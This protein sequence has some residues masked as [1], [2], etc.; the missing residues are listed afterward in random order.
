M[1]QRGSWVIAR[2]LRVELLL[3][4][5]RDKRIIAEVTSKEVV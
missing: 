4:R 1:R 2:M 3:S 5:M